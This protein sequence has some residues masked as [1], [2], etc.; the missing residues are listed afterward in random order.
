MA[1]FGPEADRFKQAG[2]TVV[3]I[4]AEKRE[5]MFKPEAFLKK[6]PA[7]FPFLL[8]EDRKVTREYG[9]YH[10]IGLDAIN[11]ARPATFVI[12]AKGVLRWMYIGSSQTDRA[13]MERVIEE[14]TKA[15]TS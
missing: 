15:T 6:T 9:V 11:I 1:Q 12:D 10:R 2:L 5:G 14:A 8:D 4:A 13:P 3:F 7:P